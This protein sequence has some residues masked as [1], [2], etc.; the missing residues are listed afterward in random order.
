MK[1]LITTDAYD[2]MVNGV[3]VSVK[4]LSSALGEAGN[5]VR[6]LTLSQTRHSYRDGNVYYIG[7][8]PLKIYPDVRATFAFHSPLLEDIVDWEPDVIHSQSEFF[9]FVFARKL[10]RLLHIPFIHTYHTL[11]EYYTHYF[12]PSKS[13]GHKIV[14]VGSRMICNR[15][16]AVIAPTLKTAGILEGY[17]V[18]SEIRVIPTGLDLGKFELE[19]FEEVACDTMLSE[20]RTCSNNLKVR[21]HIPEDAPVIVTLGRLAREK[22]IDF[23]IQQMQHPSLR[24]MGLHLLIVGDGPDRERL[25][26]LAHHLRLE[27]TVHF[28][29]MVAPENVA[30]FYRLGNAFVSASSSETQGLTYIE[31]MAC[32]LPLLCLEDPCL[33][34]V[35]ISGHNGFYFKNADEFVQHC[36]RLFESNHILNV[37]GQNALSF[38]SNFSKETF[39]MRA[40]Q[41][42]ME[43]I[44]NSG[45]E[46]E[47]C[48]K[49]AC[50]P[51][52]IW[53]KVTGY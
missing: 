8:I 26:S 25:E 21:L 49:F 40:S 11:Y 45:R 2:A 15:A 14:S 6:I 23:L 33:E 3:A 16:N 28:T 35:L 46:I 24:E 50:I 52:Q 5:D 29:G 9:T 42:Y 47:K 51:K 41:L 32:G 4:N 34:S 37:M 10:A 12:C 53:R 36:C 31:A 38:A 19:K 20:T 48:T 7:S 13:L 39:A 43:T 1:I 27:N 18:D 30:R 17:G 44:L 22:N